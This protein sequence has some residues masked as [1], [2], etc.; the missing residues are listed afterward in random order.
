MCQNDLDTVWS[1][2][3]HNVKHTHAFVEKEKRLHL[4]SGK[5]FI[6]FMHKQEEQQVLENEIVSS[7]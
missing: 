4:R 5:H 1:C 6:K 2:V 7:S 3:K